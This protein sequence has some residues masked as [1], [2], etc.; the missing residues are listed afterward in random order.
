MADAPVYETLL[1]TEPRPNV[2]L[3]TLNRPEALNTLNTK[4]GEEL[5]AV[6]EGL[7]PTYPDARAVVLTGAGDRAF[8]AGADLK[9]R[10]SLD[11]WE[12]EQQHKTFERAG[13][14]LARVP[15]PVIAAVNGVA[16]GGGCEIA[17]TCDFIVAATRARFG[18]PE[19]LRGIM[20]GLGG[21][22]RL[23]RRVGIDRAK[24]LLYTGRLVDAREAMRI[25]LVNDVIDW[26]AL[27]DRVW[28]MT[29]S[30]VAAAPL[31][32]AAIKRAVDDGAGLPLE[33]ALRIELHEYERVAR[34][35]DRREG[36]NA[37]NEKR[38]PRFLGR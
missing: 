1:V 28:E 7:F 20:P 37:F 33:Q 35:E 16:L 17:M 36:I 22:Q 14:A 8:C 32:I 9:E 11:D 21:T 6:F 19:A 30:I 31:A 5:V 23:V 24:E 4:M 3:V 18:Q 27:M 13:A 10:Q 15:V 25:G 12:W 29:S 26:T 34:T 2:V 38:A